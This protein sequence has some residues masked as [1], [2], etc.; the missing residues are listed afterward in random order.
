[1]QHEQEKKKGNE[2]ELLKALVREHVEKLA[3]QLEE[4]EVARLQE[5]QQSL[6]EWLEEHMCREIERQKRGQKEFKL[7]IVGKVDKF[8]HEM[9]EE[10]TTVLEKCE[11]LAEQLRQYETPLKY[12]DQRPQLEQEW[13]EQGQPPQ[14]QRE[15]ELRYEAEKLADNDQVAAQEE[16]TLDAAE[17]AADAQEMRYEAEKL[18]DNELGD[19]AASWQTQCQREKSEVSE[20]T[21]SCRG[22]NEG[23]PSGVA[24]DTQE[25]P[26]L[27]A[28]NAQGVPMLDLNQSEKNEATADAHMVGSRRSTL[29]YGDQEEHETTAKYLPGSFRAPTVATGTSTGVASDGPSGFALGA[30]KSAAPV[31]PTSAAVKNSAERGQEAASELP[32]RADMFKPKPGEWDCQAC[33][34]C[35]T[36][37]RYPPTATIRCVLCW[38][39]PGAPA[40]A[41]VGRSRLDRLI[42]TYDAIRAAQAAQDALRAEWKEKEK[43]RPLSQK[44]AVA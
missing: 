34:T 31:Q 37:A 10:V 17:V 1:M 23:E 28:A 29:P 43:L 19:K 8:I 36:L 38:E 14:K 25:E 22:P 3:P 15:A 40:Q 41:E 2:E 24:A 6:E 27:D 21:D 44:V 18:A 16:P 39:K 7:T 26:K 9:Q 12:N 35:K 5:Y 13:P 32:S 30:T 33:K 11:K 20:G 42:E 4:K